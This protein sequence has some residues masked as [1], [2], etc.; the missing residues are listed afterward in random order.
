MGNRAGQIRME[1][2]APGSRKTYLVEA[3]KVK[4]IALCALLFW[5]SM[6]GGLGLLAHRAKKPA[7]IHGVCKGATDLMPSQKH[8]LQLFASGS[9]KTQAREEHH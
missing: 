1:T 6:A 9:G 4:L 2:C 5:I 7:E 8:V 3:G